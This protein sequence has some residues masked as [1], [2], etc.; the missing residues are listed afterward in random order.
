MVSSGKLLFI[1]E[2]FYLSRLEPMILRNRSIED[3]I[4]TKVVGF[5]GTETF[6]ED[7]SRFPE[8]YHMQRLAL[9][10]EMQDSGHLRDT[11][12]VLT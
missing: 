5:K 3:R 9:A 4:D 1:M 2:N 11:R 7:I 10:E 12:T 8:E 6:I